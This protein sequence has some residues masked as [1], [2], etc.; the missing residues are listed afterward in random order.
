MSKE[1]I[2]LLVEWHSPGTTTTVVRGLAGRDRVHEA[3]ARV[4]ADT[5]GTTV[6]VLVLVDNSLFPAVSAFGAKTKPKTA[7]GDQPN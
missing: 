7:S 2:L 3:L 1:V 6:V 5:G 4:R